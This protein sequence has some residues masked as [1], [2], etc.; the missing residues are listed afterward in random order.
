MK[1]LSLLVL[2][3]SLIVISC[4]KHDMDM[5][6]E[7][8]VSKLN[9]D[10]P[11]A[12]VVNGESNSI[13]VI[14]LSDNTVAGTAPFGSSA[15][16]DMSMGNDIMWPHHIAINSNKTLLA[17]GVPG[18]DL[19][20][21]HGMGGVPHTG[22][23]KIV[24]VDAVTGMITKS[25]VLPAMNHNAIFSP[26]GTEIWTSQMVEKGKVL[27]YDATSY[28]LKSTIEVKMEP[29]EITFSSDGVKAFV[30]N[31]GSDTVT[32]IKIADKAIIGQIKTDKEPVGAWTGA[33]GNMYVDNEEGK[34]I[35]VIKAS[36]L[37][38][39]TTIPLEYMP[40]MAVY[41]STNNELWVTDPMK[42]MVHW[43]TKSGIIYTHGGKFA[44]ASGAHAIAFLKDGKTAYITNQLA[45]SVSVADVMTH[46]ETKEITVGKKPNGIVIKQ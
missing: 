14:K 31:S 27:V 24:I 22:G 12:Y 8:P 26:D 18:M 5:D 1:F 11:A 34:S 2:S 36:D 30:A 9:I 19:S 44:T 32:A 40:G 3:T 23:G 15:S 35:T 13:S 29:A 16:H 4:K 42:G 17:I 45:S 7:T 38:I 21:G 37:S 43:Y 6:H 25:I 46:V 41:N 33:D 20:A 10:F 39:V 28:Q